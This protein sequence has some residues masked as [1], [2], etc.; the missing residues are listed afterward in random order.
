MA[1]VIEFYVP[2]RF[3]MKVKWISPGTARKDDR[4]SGQ[5]REVGLSARSGPSEIEDVAEPC[6]FGT[7]RDQ[8]VVARGVRN[9]WEASKPPPIALAD[10]RSTRPCPEPWLRGSSRCQHSP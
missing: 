5:L 4:V 2:D 6:K 8:R 7:F 10:Y 9:K 1:Q 3:H